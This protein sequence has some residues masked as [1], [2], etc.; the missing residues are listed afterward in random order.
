MNTDKRLIT[1]RISDLFDQCERYGEAKFSAFLDGGEIAV[2]EDDFHIPYG[3][4]VMLFGGY[5]NAERKILG[6]FPEWEDA[7]EEKFPLS[8]I[9]FDAPKFRELSH[10]D[11]LGSIMSR[12]IERNKTGDILTDDTGAF[13]IAD[14]SIAEYIIRNTKKIATAGVKGSV[15][16]MK[17]FAAPK[18]KTQE[19]SCVA[20]SLRLDAIIAAAYNIS[21]ATAERLV[22]EGRVK[23]NHRE[24][25]SRSA[26][27][28]TGDLISVKGYGRFILKD[29]GRETQKGR[30]HITVEKYV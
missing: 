10:R 7:E 26:A 23:L 5:E 29:T 2:I 11:D 18:P 28:D 16:P 1:A 24:N 20:A 17:E 3:F 12:G 27:V 8:V 21:R 6:V 13:V 4:N 15:I 22:K 30:L 9:R 19:K 14:S 25:P